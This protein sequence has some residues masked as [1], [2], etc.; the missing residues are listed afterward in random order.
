V[1]SREF[2]YFM[3]NEDEALRL[4][5]K[6]NR[7]VVE[8]QALFA[9]IKPGMRVIDMGCGS[10]K[11][12]SILHALAQPGGKAVGLDISEN[13]IHY[14][15]DHYGKEGIRFVCMDMRHSLDE[16]G[17]F[18][19][20]WIR[21]VLEYYRTDAWSIVQHVARILKPG[22]ILCLIDLDYNCMNHF[23]LPE[24]ADK[25]TRELIEML[26]VKANFDPYMGRK[27]YSYLYRMDFTDIKVNVGAH[28]LIYGNL[29]AVDSYN[30]IKKMEVASR[31][32]NFDFCH[33]SSG[34]SEY[35]EEFTAF[36]SDPGRFTYT[37]VISVRGCKTSRG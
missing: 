9:G 17:K 10:G 1:D 19:F 23:E 37:P 34:Y 11:T 13:R 24:R 28:H 6:T 20:L 21:F 8:E 18:D 30:W 22:G 25:T 35:A 14:A 36:L 2:G 26:E 31:K 15:L 16:L 7:D 5:L 12:T 33:Y 32:I 3:E 27:L 29:S 4:D